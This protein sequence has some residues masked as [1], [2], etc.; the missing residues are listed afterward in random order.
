M[1]KPFLLFFPPVYILDQD[2]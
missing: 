2:H 1:S